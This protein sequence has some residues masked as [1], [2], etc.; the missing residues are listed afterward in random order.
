MF[1]MFLKFLLLLSIFNATLQYSPSPIRTRR[2]ILTEGCSITALSWLLLPSDPANAAKGAAELDFEYYMKDLFNGNKREGPSQS[3]VRPPA[4]P[5]R[6]LSG[7]LLSLL[8]DDECSAYCIPVQALIQTIGRNR[9]KSSGSG[10]DGG[11]VDNK[12]IEKEIQERVSSYKEKTKKSFYASTP[13]QEENVSDQ[14]YFDFISYTLWRTAADMVPDYIDRD[15]FARD[16]GKLL[17]ENLQ[18][19]KLITK[20]PSPKKD[21]ATGNDDALVRTI[22]TVLSIL[23]LFKSSQYCTGYRIKGEDSSDNNDG[24]F[25]FDSLDDETLM[26]GGTVNCLVSVYLPSTLGASLQI[27]GEQSRFSPDF[28]G[29]TLSALWETVGI[30]SSWETFFVDGE[31]RPNPK[32]YFPNEQLIQFTLTKK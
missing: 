6:T 10:G 15:K 18:D 8:L 14:Y 25:F 23:E 11:N 4:K 29:T 13:W 17:Y 3:P 9:Q 19:Q 22:P 26:S 28:V 24:D 16:I 12:T 20:V 2:S 7:P 27:T 1:V 31:Y 21:D 5:P 30:R 32:D